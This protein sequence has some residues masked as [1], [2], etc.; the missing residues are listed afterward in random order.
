M[1]I[2]LVKSLVWVIAF[3]FYGDLSSQG[4]HF[5][6]L[7]FA[8]QSVNPGLIGGFLGSYRGT[9]IYRSQYN[10]GAEVKG[11][12][13]FEL[14]IDVPIIR[15]F[16]KQDWIG[17]GISLNSDKRGLFSFTDTYSRLG[18]SYHFSLDKKQISVLT[19]GV[20]IININ[21]SLR[22]PDENATG[23]Q[24]TNNSSNDP[25]LLRLFKSADE[26]GRISATGRDWNVGLVYTRTSKTN[27]VKVGFSGSGFFP[28]RLG[29]Q[30][31]FELPLRMIGFASMVNQL[32]KTMT[33]EPMAI[34]QKA[35]YGSEIMFNTKLGY[36]YNKE[37]N[38]KV[39]AGLGF[40]TGTFSAIFFIGG[41][42]KGINFGLSYD[43]PLSGY[44]GA[45]GIQ[46]GFEFGASY[47][48]VLKKTPKP[49][50]IIICP[51]L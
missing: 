1:R 11:Y 31:V 4:I 46:N 10:N 2:I 51:R 7:E 17:G 42:I 13:T 12:N 45:P 43:L 50:P 47:I 6:Y 39:K 34:F 36:K 14:G 18:L 40:R 41:E 30:E 20:Q 25:D 29:F 3:M 8:P 28:V 9:G 37:K 35:G 5:S 32:N 49:K 27:L 19:L 22:R 33:L 38:D 24:I 15:G 21:R 26:K 48:G 23:Y 44:S 16:R